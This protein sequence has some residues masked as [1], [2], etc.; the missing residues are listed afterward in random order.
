MAPN[1][2]PIAHLDALPMSPAELVIAR[3]SMGFTPQSLADWLDV[4]AELVRGWE[5]GAEPIPAEIRDDIRD[6][7][8]QADVFEES[9][10][11]RLMDLPDPVVV[12]YR[13]DEEYRANADDGE[14]P[15]SFHRAIMARVARRLPGLALRF[16]GEH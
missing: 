4:P 16:P 12:V 3:E 8:R 9:A 11:G 5:D 7:Q 6:M 10:V 13:T 1:Q 14:L 15:A 2:D